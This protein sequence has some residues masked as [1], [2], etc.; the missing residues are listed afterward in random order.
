MVLG[1][2]TFE[3]TPAITNVG[4]AAHGTAVLNDNGT[5]GDTT[6]DFIVYTPNADYNGSDSFT[7]TVTSG[8]VTETA[9]V[10]MTVNAVADIADDSVSVLQGSGSNSLDLLANDNFESAGRSI[11]RGRRGPPRH[12]R[13]QQ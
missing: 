1:N 12:R 13:D 11:T 8:G 2:D 7:Y 9:T 5:P 4:A 3:G 10:N 6:D